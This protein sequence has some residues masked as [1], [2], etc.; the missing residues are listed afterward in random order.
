MEGRYGEDGEDGGDGGKG[1]TWS[2]IAGVTGLPSKLLP[3]VNRPGWG[4]REAE[5][6]LSLFLSLLLPMV[7]CRP[8]E[9][10][11]QPL[12]AGPSSFSRCPHLQGDPRRPLHTKQGDPH[13][14]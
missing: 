5:S 2:I 1:A 14:S 4:E 12:P 8:P 11:A 13:P 10:A 7:S 3:L 9:P 6:Q